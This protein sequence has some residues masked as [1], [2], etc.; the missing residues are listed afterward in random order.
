MSKRDYKSYNM[1]DEF[2]EED[3]DDMQ[4]DEA[5]EEN[6][7]SQALMQDDLDEQTLE[8]VE[9]II[10]KESVQNTY[11]A[12][13]QEQNISDIQL[14]TEPTLISTEEV[15]KKSMVSL[16]KKNIEREDQETSFKEEKSKSK[17]IEKEVKDNK[18]TDS[19]K[20][21]SYK[22]YY[23]QKE[24]STLFKWL[25]LIAK[26]IITLMLLPLI[27]V[28]AFCIMFAVGIIA[29]T[30]L[31]SVAM[32]ILFLTCVCFMATQLSGNLIA[33]GISVAITCIAFAGIVLVLSLALFKWLLGLIKKYKKPR[34]KNCQKE[35]R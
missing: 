7:I 10:V 13:I 4:Q 12:E 28:I 15:P 20:L 33:L 24:R 11:G 30:I 22:K 9:T 27:G 19:L 23:Q 14:M 25:M 5:L 21:S 32:G 3:L 2:I 34:I 35:V 8:V 18:L 29:L 31:G 26:I 16:L 1:L 17:C 6:E